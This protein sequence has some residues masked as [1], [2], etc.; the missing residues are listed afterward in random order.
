MK[1]SG[2]RWCRECKSWQ[3]GE[4]FIVYR[5]GKRLPIATCFDCLKKLQAKF[6]A[7]KKARAQ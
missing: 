7:E 5:G 6:H 4:R 3:D 1:G 2:A